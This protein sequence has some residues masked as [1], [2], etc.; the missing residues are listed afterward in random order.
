MRHSGVLDQ[1]KIWSLKENRAQRGPLKKIYC[2]ELNQSFSGNY[3]RHIV[4]CAQSIQCGERA[5]P[6]IQKLVDKLSK[7]YVTAKGSF[8][9]QWSLIW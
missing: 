1:G 3:A 6:A 2:K 5:S 8:N 7:N 4:G 9:E